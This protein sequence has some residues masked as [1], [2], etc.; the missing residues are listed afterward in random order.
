MKESFENNSK[1][2]QETQISEW[3]NVAERSEQEKQNL[4][5][6]FGHKVMR[7]VTRMLERVSNNSVVDKIEEKYEE[8]RRKRIDNI[9]DELKNNVP[10]IDPEKYENWNALTETRKTRFQK[11]GTVALDSLGIRTKKSEETLNRVALGIAQDELE[12]EQREQLWQQKQQQDKEKEQQLR[13]K[14]A[15]AIE[16]GPLTPEQKKEELTFDKLSKLSTDEY[17]TLWLRLNPYYVSHV[18]RQGIRDH[19]CGTH[20]DGVGEWHN[21]LTEVLKDKKIVPPLAI[22]MGTKGNIDKENVASYLSEYGKYIGN[23]REK[24]KILQ[25]INEKMADKGSIHFMC[26]DVGDDQY[27]AEEN[28]EC[29][30]IFPTDVIASQ[31]Q[32]APEGVTNFMKGLERLNDSADNVF[33]NLYV[34]PPTNNDELGSIPIDAGLVFLPKSTIVDPNT[35]SKYKTKTITNIDGTTKQVVAEQAFEKT[36]DGYPFKNN[37]LVKDGVTAQEYYEKYFT[38]HPE[39][40]PAHIIYYDG[41]PDRAVEELLMKKGIS[42]QY[43]IDGK[44]GPGDT[45][46]KQGEYLGFEDNKSKS[47]DGEVHQPFHDKHNP[48]ERFIERFNSLAQEIIEEESNNNQ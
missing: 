35:G 4:F 30:F 14:Q 33:N 44:E 39:Q 9:K 31:C 27:G 26:Q 15:E 38:E 5:Q 19:T 47:Q 29:F 18:T 48:L 17:L 24:S 41:K 46:V 13:E 25:A 23:P 28:N 21:G 6:R 11:I 42:Y 2:S 3:D 22:L 34:Y 20:L 32:F 10:L 7:I 43:P 16:K 8:N 12:D 45:S 37:Y 40:K 36:P 1:S